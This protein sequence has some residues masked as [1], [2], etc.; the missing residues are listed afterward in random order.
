[1]IQEIR[2]RKKAKG[3]NRK[4]TLPDGI[5]V[6]VNDIMPQKWPSPTRCGLPNWHD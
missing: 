3:G 4:A 2:M 1:M 6:L 5:S